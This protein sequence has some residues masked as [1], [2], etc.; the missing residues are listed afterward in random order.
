[1]RIRWERTRR[2]GRPSR[3]V[4]RRRRRRT[5]SNG[6]YQ[7]GAVCGHEYCGCS[8]AACCLQCPT[9]FC[10]YDLEGK[11]VMRRERRA[12]VRLLS[13]R[14]LKKSQI[15]LE[16]GISVKIAEYDLTVFR[17]QEVMA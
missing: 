7:I 16:L 13:A 10:K 9:R 4:S 15:A 6:V 1:V 2:A 17:R 12:A 3:L 14:G 11:A 5:G 8:E